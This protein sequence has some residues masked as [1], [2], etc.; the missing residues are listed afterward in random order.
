LLSSQAFS[1]FSTLSSF[2]F[3]RAETFASSTCW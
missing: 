1:H 2:N 3:C